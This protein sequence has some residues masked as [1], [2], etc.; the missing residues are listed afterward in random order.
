MHHVAAVLFL[1]ASS[2]KS[3]AVSLFAAQKILEMKL[4]THG[5]HKDRMLLMVKWRP[6]E[7]QCDPDHL[8]KSDFIDANGAR[9]RRCQRRLSPAA[10]ACHRR[11]NTLLCRNAY[12]PISYSTL[13]TDPTEAVPGHDP[14]LCTWEPV[15]NVC[16]SAKLILDY[17]KRQPFPLPGDLDAVIGGPPCQVLRHLAGRNRESPALAPFRPLDAPDSELLR[18]QLLGVRALRL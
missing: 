15:S 9:L 17:I 10:L 7:W 8:L 5:I 2:R 16:G 6:G 13:F 3:C 4:G 14:A 18:R 12:H 1:F 11:R